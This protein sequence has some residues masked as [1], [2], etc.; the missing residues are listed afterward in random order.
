[1]KVW[2]LRKVLADNIVILVDACNLD[3]CYYEVEEKVIKEVEVTKN[4]SVLITTKEE[5]ED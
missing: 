3:N 2:E 4:G 5:W 1:M